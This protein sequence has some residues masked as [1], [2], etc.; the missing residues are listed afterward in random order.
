MDDQWRLPETIE[1]GGEEYEIRT[2]F[3]VILDIL[4]AMADPE[5]SDQEKS[6]VML[7]ILY[8]DPEE[9]PIE[10]LNEALEKGK[11]FIDCGITA[12]QKQSSVNGWEQDSPI[13]HRQSTKIRKRHPFSGIHALVDVSWGLY[14]DCGR[15]VQP[16]ALYSPEESQRKETGKWEMEFYRNNKE[17]ID[18]KQTVKK[19]SAE[20][21]AALNELFGIKK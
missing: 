4:K 8:W 7:E 1:L 15:A 6:Q 5:L 16:G 18:L 19:R 14:G 21:E 12:K 11:E 2:D 10:Y 13:L 20:E 9:I 3:R 17:L